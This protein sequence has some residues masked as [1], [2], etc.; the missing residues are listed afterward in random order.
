MCKICLD[1]LILTKLSEDLEIDSDHSL[2]Y[3]LT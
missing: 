1:M 3:F 2:A